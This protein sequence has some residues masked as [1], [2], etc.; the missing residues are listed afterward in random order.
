MFANSYTFHVGPLSVGNGGPNPITIPPFNPVEYE[1]VWVHSKNRELSIGLVP[2]IL[3]G[4]RFF[5]S[6]GAYVSVGAGMLLDTNGLGPGL[7]TAIG[8]D[9]CTSSGY[10]FNA[11][12]KKGLG[13]TYRTLIAPYALRI[14]LTIKGL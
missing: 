10:C 8:Y 4:Q 14:G 6:E 1:F 13:L 2:G 3:Y 12:Y 7:Y 11:E 9:A 5:L